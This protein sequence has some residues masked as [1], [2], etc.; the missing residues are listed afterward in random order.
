MPAH[1]AGAGG[2][3]VE[4]SATRRTPESRCRTEP[5]QRPVHWTAPRSTSTRRAARHRASR[6]SGPSPCRSLCSPGSHPPGKRAG[7]QR[8]HGD[9]LITDVR[10]ERAL[11]LE[12]RHSIHRRERQHADRRTGFERRERSQGEHR[13]QGEHV[14]G[15]IVADLASDSDQD[16]EQKGSCD[17]VTGPGSAE[18]VQPHRS[19][20]RR[21]A[22]TIARACG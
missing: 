15:L 7:D 11:G 16:D 12:E 8:E 14:S 3:R 2:R 5:P 1:H 18:R 17:C 13:D 20:T 9:V 21:C 4:E 22:V 10:R 6:Q 19:T